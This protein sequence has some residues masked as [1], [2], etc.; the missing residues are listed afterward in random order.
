MLVSWC[1]C[2]DFVHDALLPHQVLSMS[3]CGVRYV[4]S[5]AAF[6]TELEERQDTMIERMLEHERRLR[7]LGNEQLFDG[8]ACKNVKVS[9]I[10][11]WT[12]SNVYMCV[13]VCG[14]D[15]IG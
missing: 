14:L 12:E 13:S 11:V 6:L 8:N 2:M 7:S 4:H 5:C 3:H 10:C 15:W 1:V 9:N